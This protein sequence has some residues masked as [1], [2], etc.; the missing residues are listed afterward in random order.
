MHGMCLEV[1]DIVVRDPKL[2]RLFNIPPNLWPAVKKSWQEE[3]QKDFLGRF[4]WSW[5]GVNKPKLLE[6]NGDTPSLLLES[7]KISKD[8]HRDIQ[9]QLPQPNYQSNYLDEAL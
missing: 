6:Y 4:D 5:D 7:G 1:V 2:M 9:S 8:W 3:K